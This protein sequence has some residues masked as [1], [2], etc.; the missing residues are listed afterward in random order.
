M[1]IFATS[2]L[3]DSR[4]FCLRNVELQLIDFAI[5]FSQSCYGI[6]NLPRQISSG[7]FEFFQL[8][9]SFFYHDQTRENFLPCQEWRFDSKIR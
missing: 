7:F 4:L 3:V 1:E 9:F 2:T 5:E 8:L 6:F